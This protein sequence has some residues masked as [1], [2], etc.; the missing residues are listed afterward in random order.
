[1]TLLLLAGTASPV[2]VAIMNYDNATWTADEMQAAYIVAVFV[3]V[4][5]GYSLVLSDHHYIPPTVTHKAFISSAVHTAL[6]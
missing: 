5:N 4:L 6:S 2:T 1:M 3:P